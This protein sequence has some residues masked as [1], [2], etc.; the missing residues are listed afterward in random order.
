MRTVRRLYFYAVAFISL[1]V[2]L[3][4]MIGLA[5]SIACQATSFCGGSA[6]LTQGLAAIIVGIPFFAVHWWASQRF[7]RQDM[8]ERASGVR[9]VFLYGLM[10]ATLIPIVQNLLSLLDRLALQAVNLSTSQAFFGPNQT[11]TDN[12]IAMLMN[13]VFAAYFW[14][15]L[16]GDWRV[17]DPQ[18]TYADIRR[19]YRHIWLVYS[20]AMVVAGVE[21]LLRFI[22]DILRLS[23]F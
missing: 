22:L 17:I 3:W 14:N 21:Q 13:A 15:I 16:R 19:I 6:I 11:W 18:E 23:W 5:R 8:E 10:L 20:L 12:L 7:A 1:E 2:I 9:A 4:G